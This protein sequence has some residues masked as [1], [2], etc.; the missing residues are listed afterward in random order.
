MI[1]TGMNILE[2]FIM[3]HT[4]NKCFRISHKCWVGVVGN[5]RYASTYRS[6]HDMQGEGRLD[7]AV[8]PDISVKGH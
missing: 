4:R 7:W 5:V 8:L 3:Q 1:L 2:T 6:R